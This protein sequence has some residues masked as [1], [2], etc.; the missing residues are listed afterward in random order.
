[1]NKG[2]G[3]NMRVGTEDNSFVTGKNVGVGS[4]TMDDNLVSQAS[5][6]W[7]WRKELFGGEQPLPTCTDSVYCIFLLHFSIKFLQILKQ[8]N[9]QKINQQWLNYFNQ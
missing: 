8:T 4:S 6:E 5:G 3:S 7:Q 2:F 1:M 9:K